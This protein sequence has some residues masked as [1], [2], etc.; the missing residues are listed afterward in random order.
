M[1]EGKFPLPLPKEYD[2]LL[3]YHAQDCPYEDARM[4]REY[5]D[6]E[7]QIISQEV[8]DLISQ[9]LF[10]QETMTEALFRM[11]FCLALGMQAHLIGQALYKL[12]EMGMV[13]SQWKYLQTMFLD[14]M[15]VETIMWEAHDEVLQRLPDLH[16]PSSHAG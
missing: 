4:I 11:R 15:A 16:D 1:Q 3:E 10:I 2:E 8:K 12:K 13:L 9:F 14:V 7:I 6:N 5:I